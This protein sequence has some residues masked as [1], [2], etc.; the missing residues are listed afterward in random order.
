MRS[1]V[2]QVSIIGP[3]LFTV[4]INDLYNVYNI[5]QPIMSAEDTNLFSSH[6]NLELYKVT[7]W[8]KANKPSLNEGKT[9][10]TFFH[11]FLQKGNIPLKLPM[12][13]IDGKVTEWTT[14][15]KFL[16][17]L[18]DEHLSWKNHISVVE[19]KVSK[20]LE[21]YIKPKIF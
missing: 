10:C 5:I 19:N 18:L 13:A 2:S 1:G 3:L 14:S 4:Y 8:F 11:K 12:L 9:K 21:F 6:D 16:G 17:I 7:V 20:I 15:I